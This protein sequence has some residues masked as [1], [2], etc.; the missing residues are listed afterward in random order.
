[1]V[2]PEPLM[3]AGRDSEIATRH[4]KSRIAGRDLRIPARGGAMTP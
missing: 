4:I 3:E 2:L 1:M